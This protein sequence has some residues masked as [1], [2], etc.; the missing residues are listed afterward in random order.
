MHRPV[1]SIECQ[2]AVYVANVELANGGSPTMYLFVK[3]PN[4]I[5]V[6]K[7]EAVL[8]ATTGI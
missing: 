3:Q 4:L 1:L 2:H 8:G 5:S 6:H 7:N